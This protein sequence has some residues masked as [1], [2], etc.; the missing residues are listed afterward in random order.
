MK[1][2]ISFFGLVILMLVAIAMLGSCGAAKEAIFR[3]KLT[4]VWKVPQEL[5]N[6]KTDVLI[7]ITGNKVIV[8]DNNDFKGEIVNLDLAFSSNPSI[9]FYYKS[10]TETFNDLT[11]VTAKNAP[12]KYYQ[13]KVEG[14]EA[15][16]VIKIKA[17]NE[18]TWH[19]LKYHNVG[20][21]TN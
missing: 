20:P 7:Y 2:R 21:L 10:E 13:I 12:K 8:K 15:D 17:E 11:F 6:G 4:A 18:S 3:V 1:K 9:A 19:V 5:A 16:R 14:K